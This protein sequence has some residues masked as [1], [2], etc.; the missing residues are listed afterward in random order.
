MEEKTF[1]KS[2]LVTGIIGII[3]FLVLFFTL[4]SQFRQ[5]AEKRSIFVESKAEGLKGYIEVNASIISIDAVRGDMTVR[6]DFEPQGELNNGIGMLTENIDVLVNNASGKQEF[7][8]QKNKLMNPADITLN[9]YEGIVTEYPFDKHKTEF[10]IYTRKSLES[11]G[12][13]EENQETPVENVVNFSG[14]LT[15]Y[16]IDAQLDPEN[17]GS[18]TV[19]NLN[20]A[21]AG[22]VKFFA[23]AVMAIMWILI[24]MLM[25]VIFNISVRGKKI[26]ATMFTFISSMLFAFPAFRNM[27]PFAPPIGALPDYAA[28]FWAEGTAAVS[29]VIMLLVWFFRKDSVK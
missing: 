19:L 17:N 11:T 25:L 12:P 10:I 28:F 24:F 29:L 18:Y 13:D 4:Y 2:Y 27:M 9:L 23:V 1:R 20:V 3:I 7:N 5:E 6:L 14:Y 8:F 26:E 15:G 22:S 21:R 16:A